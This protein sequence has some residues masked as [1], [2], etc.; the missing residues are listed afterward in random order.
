MLPILNRF[1]GSLKTVLDRFPPERRS[2]VVVSSLV[3]IAATVGLLVW[4]FRPQYKVL[5]SDLALEDSGEIVQQLQKDHVPYKLEDEGARILVPSDKLYDTRLKLA[6]VQLPRQ[7]GAGWELFDQNSLGVTDFV[8]KLN[9]RRAL[10]GELAR[11]ILQMDP[12][13]AVRVHLVIPEESLFK[14]NQRQAMASVTVRMKRGQKLSPAQVEGVGYL[15]SSAV[16]GL[17]ASNVTIID[18]RGFILSEKQ[19][20][21]PTVRLTASQLELQNRV[22]ANLVKKG[23]ELLDKR[24]GPGRSAVQVTAQ[25]D[26]E[27]REKSSEVY[28]SENPSIRSEEVTASTTSSKDTTTSSTQNNVTN[29][30]LNLTKEHVMNAPGQVKRISIAVMVDGKYNT[31]EGAKGV[32]TKEFAP[33]TQPELDD[34]SRTIQAALGYSVNRGDE[35]SVVSV[36]FLDSMMMENEDMVGGDKIDLMMKYGQKLLI[37][38]AII[39]MLL[40]VRGFLRKATPPAL[41][42]AGVEVGALGGAASSG[43]LPPG[44]SGEMPIPV[45]LEPLGDLEAEIPVEQ[46]QKQRRQ[47]QINTYVADK[48]EQAARLVRSWLIDE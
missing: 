8:Q 9:Y 5:F 33:L 1:F 38:A 2:Q 22:E 29:Y 4:A 11:T 19:E 7:K 41:A 17:E 43:M 48:P 36:P 27:T 23:Q 35:I 45:E 37:L 42:L 10:E 6:A 20:Q 28:D 40:M 18:S 21:N 13:E 26:F 30:E 46:L 14:E 12:I 3:M 31:V 44:V 32:K 47:E 25:L 34:I 39:M 15:V 24:F 16:E